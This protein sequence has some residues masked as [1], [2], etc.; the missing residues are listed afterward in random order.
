MRKFEMCVANGASLTTYLYEMKIFHHFYTCVCVDCVISC[1]TSYACLIA[2]SSFAEREREKKVNNK[3][4]HTHINFS[5][6]LAII[7]VE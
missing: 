3:P 7:S 6:Y 2:S 1:M 5:V 4:K